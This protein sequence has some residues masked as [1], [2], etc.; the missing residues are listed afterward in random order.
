MHYRSKPENVV[1]LYF[2]GSLPDSST[3]EVRPVVG[4]ERGLS[5]NTPH[6]VMLLEIISTATYQG[7]AI[8]IKSAYI[9]MRLCVADGVI[10]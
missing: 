1:M 6:H 4:A 5:Y 2:S 8:D 9:T 3:R 10:S 7:L